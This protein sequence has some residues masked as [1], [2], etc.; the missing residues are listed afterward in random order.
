MP[1]VLPPLAL[2]VPGTLVSGLAEAGPRGHTAPLSRLDPEAQVA[3]DRDVADSLA[4]GQA[5][6]FRPGPDGSV[7]A[8]LSNGG[9]QRV[10]DPTTRSWSR[11]APGAGDPKDRDDARSRPAGFGG[12]GLSPVERG[13]A[14]LL[15]R[16]SRTEAEQRSSVERAADVA[17][18]RGWRSLIDSVYGPG[19]VTRLLRDLWRNFYSDHEAIGEVY[20]YYDV[21]QRAADQVAHDRSGGARGADAAGGRQ[22]GAWDDAMRAQAR[23]AIGAYPMRVEPRYDHVGRDSRVRSEHPLSPEFFAGVWSMSYP[24]EEEPDWEQDY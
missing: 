11:P 9:G 7:S 6:T 19:A 12:H 14:Y 16:F 1:P 3:W 18:G 5:P 21:A 4:A 2:F 20:H 15:D 10:Y 13:D 22:R 17:F 23:D 24:N 8:S